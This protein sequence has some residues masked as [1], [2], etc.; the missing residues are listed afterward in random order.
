MMR[1][2]NDAHL[3]SPRGFNNFEREAAVRLA[4]LWK[5]SKEKQKEEQEEEQE[6]AHETEETCLPANK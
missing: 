2:I 4:E 1:C 3:L 5:I 6:E